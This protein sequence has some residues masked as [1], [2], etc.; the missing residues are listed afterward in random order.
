MHILLFVSQ[1]HA[2]RFAMVLPAVQAVDEVSPAL[3]QLKR[4]CNF[5]LNTRILYLV[6][7]SWN[8]LV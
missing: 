5:F 8:L 1:L 2:G 6:L 7:D 3:D 4:P